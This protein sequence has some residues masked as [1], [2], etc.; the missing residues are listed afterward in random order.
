MGQLVVMAAARSEAEPLLNGLDENGFDA[1]FVRSGLGRLHRLGGLRIRES[2]P[3]AQYN[4][5]GTC[6]SVAPFTEPYLIRAH[7][8]AWMFLGKGMDLP[9]PLKGS[10]HPFL[11]HPSGVGQRPAVAD[12]C[13]QSDHRERSRLP[14]WG[15]NCGYCRKI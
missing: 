14:R 8:T 13:L 10:S 12:R 6:G 2:L 4:L 7:K 11:S 15:G 5:L 1:V 3:W 9:G